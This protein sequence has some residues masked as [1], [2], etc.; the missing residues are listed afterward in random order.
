VTR[1][2]DIVLFAAGLALVVVTLSSTV[3]STMLPR[4]V[5]NKINRYLTLGLRVIFKLRAGRSPSYERRDRIMAMFGPVNLLALLATWLLLIIFGFVAMYLGVGVRPVANA[6]ELSGSSVFTLGSTPA[7]GFAAVTLT[8]AEAGLGLLLLT[9]LITYLT[10]IYGAFS[11]REAVVTLL[12]VRA[13]SPPSAIDMLIRFHRIGQV[14]RL[15]GLWRRWEQ[16]FV[17][18]EETHTSFPVLVQFRSPQ[19]D[20]SWVN[21]AGTVLDAAS[22]WASTV[23]HPNDPDAQLCLRAGSLALRRIAALLRVPFNPDPQPGQP[24]TISRHEFDTAC[25]EMAEAGVPLNP[26][27]DAAW[28]SFAGW[29]VN[30]DIVLLNLARLTEAPP[31]PWVSD[32]SPLEAFQR[33]S[34]RKAIMASPATRTRRLWRRARQP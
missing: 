25:R 17:E 24:V 22:L 28:V 7:H 18:V 10:T 33:W 30:Y 4:G 16:W 34:L 12:E 11:R 21:A 20:H 31:A 6:F 3:R 15:A 9:L 8:Y 1:A 26:D 13:G 14:D 27:L 23:E 19:P 2:L 5:T 29:R 32:R